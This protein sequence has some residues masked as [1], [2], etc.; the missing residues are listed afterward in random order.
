MPDMT[1]YKTVFE[2]TVADLRGHQDRALL[3]ALTEQAPGSGEE[4]Y[5][6]GILPPDPEDFTMGTDWDTSMD[7]GNFREAYEA[8][9]KTLADLQ[10]MLT[11]HTNIRRQATRVVGKVNDIGHTF[12]RHKPILEEINLNSRTMR[13]LMKEIWRRQDERVIAALAG[14]VQRKDTAGDLGSP[15][16]LP[17]GQ[18][19]TV[20]TDANFSFTKDVI[21]T[22]MEIFEGN[23]INPTQENIFALISPA[24]KYS[25]IKTEGG[26]IHN[27]DFV[28]K[29]MVFERGELPD[30]YGAKLLVHPAV[31]GNDVI[32]WIPDAIAYRQ[33]S[34]LQT[35]MQVS[36]A[37]RFQIFAQIEEII[38]V[39]RT[40]DKGVVKITIDDGQ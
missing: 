1:Y 22:A 38:G 13:M 14:N 25:L 8:S 7:E 34:P 40:D 4:M 2:R 39:S 9:S 19:D 29:P 10:K 6:Y 24:H 18:T 21:A 32:F 15:T 11:P 28:S 5:V 3:P 27:K 35:D 37:F 23:H 12:N 36:G 30:I 33:F 26:T 20:V 17:A 16:G 31:T